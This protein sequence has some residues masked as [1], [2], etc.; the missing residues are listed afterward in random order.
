MMTGRD[1]YGQLGDGSTNDAGL[2]VLPSI[3]GSVT[4]RTP[5][6]GAAGASSLPIPAGRSTRSRSNR[7][8]DLN[9]AHPLP[10]A[11]RDRVAVGEMVDHVDARLCRSRG[12][13]ES[14][15]E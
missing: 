1:Q 10:V 2:P 9:D 5:V 15:R 12:G 11:E 7:G 4:S 13:R 3:A 8:V 14:D 6:P